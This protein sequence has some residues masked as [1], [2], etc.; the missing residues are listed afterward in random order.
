MAGKTSKIWM[1][2]SIYPRDGGIR[3]AAQN[4][5]GGGGGAAP[6]VCVDEGWSS[7]NDGLNFR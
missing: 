6:A 2:Q 1:G 5:R 7:R 3:M 4:N